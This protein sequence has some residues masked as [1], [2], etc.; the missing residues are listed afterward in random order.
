[1]RARETVASY[2]STRGVSFATGICE[3][4]AEDMARALSGH[5]EQGQEIAVH[6]YMAL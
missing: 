1:M 4:P 6:I 5:E 2:P 3:T